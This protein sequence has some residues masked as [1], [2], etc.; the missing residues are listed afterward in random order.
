MAVVLVV[1]LVT[2]A[3]LV[4]QVVVVLTKTSQEELEIQTLLQHIKEI[5]VE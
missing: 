2:L 4:D 1:V 3:R 5:L